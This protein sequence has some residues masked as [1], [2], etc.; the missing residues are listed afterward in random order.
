MYHKMD[1][2]SVRWSWI[3]QFPLV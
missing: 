3:V 2:K 1:A